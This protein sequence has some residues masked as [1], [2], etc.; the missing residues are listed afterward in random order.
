MV[1]TG[2]TRLLRM[3]SLA[4]LA[5]ALLGFAFAAYVAV[6]EFFGNVPVQGWTSVMVAILLTTGAI[7]FALGVVAEYIGVAVNMAMG[8]P[9]YLIVGDRATGP[10]GRAPQREDVT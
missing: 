3:V 6:A 9:L 1:I 4:G 10:H 5:L 2:G 7:L 8:K